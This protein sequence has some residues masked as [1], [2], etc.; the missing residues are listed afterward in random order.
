MS[1]KEYSVDT[2]V[3]DLC[4]DIKR[5]GKQ[6]GSGAYI[7]T[8]GVLFVDP[9]VEQRYESLF[10][11]LKAARTRGLIEFKGQLLLKGAHDNVEIKLLP[12]K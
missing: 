9:Q 11:T 3:K 4:E 5:I 8:F 2:E 10:G 7:T 1:G 12:P 6:D